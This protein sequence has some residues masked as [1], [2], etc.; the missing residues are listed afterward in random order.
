VRRIG[1]SFTVLVRR[2]RL[3]CDADSG[4]VARRIEFC[5]MG[6]SGWEATWFLV[7]A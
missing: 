5:V 7:S 6:R 3:A 1:S 4:L 2:K